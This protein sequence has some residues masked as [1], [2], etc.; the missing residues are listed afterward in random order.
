MSLGLK[1]KTDKITEEKNEIRN[2][3]YRRLYYQHITDLHFLVHRHRESDRKSKP[4]NER[5]ILQQEQQQ[6][7]KTKAIKGKHKID[8]LSI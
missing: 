2:N 7:R 4:T 1:G 3:A 5:V 6:K 8:F